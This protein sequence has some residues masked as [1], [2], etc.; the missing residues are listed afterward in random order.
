MYWY[1][2]FLTIWLL[3]ELSCPWGCL[4]SSNLASH[5]FSLGQSWLLGSLPPA[6]FLACVPLQSP[7]AGASHP[8]PWF[9]SSSLSS[10]WSAATPLAAVLPPASAAAGPPAQSPQI[11]S[12]FVLSRA[13]GSVPKKLVDKVRSGQ[14]ME[15]REFLVDN[16]VLQDR[17]EA[18]QGQNYHILGSRPRLREVSTPL[19]W[20]C[21]FLAYVAIATSDPVTRDQLAY[22]C[23]ILGEA[24]SQGGSG[25]LHYDRAFRQL[26][27]ADPTLPWSLG[28]TLSWCW[29]S[30]QVFRF[31]APFARRVIMMLQSVRWHLFVTNSS[32]YNH[33]PW[34]HLIA[35]HLLGGLG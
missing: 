19:S 18:L 21:C 9:Q 14:F 1:V 11:S 20:A 28:C 27:V 32:L 34:G 8:L 2:C 29:G 35:L 31:S 4:Y 12:G 22:A 17:L 16:L 5:S 6:S 7:V 15:M 13:S 3:V 23:L 25:W 30:V 10:T 26:K 33:N 24:Q